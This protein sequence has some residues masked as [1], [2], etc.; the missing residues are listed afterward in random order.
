MRSS[1]FWTIPNFIFLKIIKKIVYKLFFLLKND[2]ENQKLIKPLFFS[3]II[4]NLKIGWGVIRSLTVSL[5]EF[6]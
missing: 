4:C 1:S 6:L 5:P 3:V 2:L